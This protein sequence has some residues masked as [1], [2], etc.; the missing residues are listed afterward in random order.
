MDVCDARQDF[1][2]DWVYDLTGNERLAEILDWVVERPLKVAFI[3]LVAAM[4][5]RFVRQM[6]GRAEIRMMEDRDRKL[7]LRELDE[8]GDGRFF[9]LQHKALAKARDLA[10]GAERSKQRAQTLATLLESVA[11]VTILALAVMIS[12]GELDVSLGPLLAGAGIIGI[13]IGFGAQAVVRDFLAG[14]F[15]LVE[16]QY[17]VGDVVDF[18]DA[19]GVVE[20]ISLRTTRLRDL[21][22]TVW[23]V[24]NGEIRRVANKSYSW[25][26]CVLDIPVA[27]ETDIDVAAQVIKDAADSVWA[28]HLE[29]ATILE[30]P[31]IWGVEDLGE[32]AV[33]IRLVVKTEPGEQWATSREIRRRVKLAFQQEG[34]VIPFPQRMVWSGG[35]HTAGAPAG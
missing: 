11:T 34:I 1:I 5:S 10:R 4:L 9:A 17:G 18:G 21:N 15:M 14:I 7:H 12:L 35:G 27:Y 8:V 33:L 19:G 2:C 22:G 25:A 26:R 24:P 29:T 3:L 16:D 23:Y 13:A 31:E 32:S 28:E 30:E 6:I 20:E